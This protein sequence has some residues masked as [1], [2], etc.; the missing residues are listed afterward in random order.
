MNGKQ[1]SKMHQPY[2][3]CDL[4]RQDGYLA[5]NNTQAHLFYF[6]FI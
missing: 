3:T 1:F 6:L 2:T 5:I 4:L